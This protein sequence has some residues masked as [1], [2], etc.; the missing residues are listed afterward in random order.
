MI[1]RS[2]ISLFFLLLGAVFCSASIPLHAQNRPS[3]TKSDSTNLVVRRLKF[4]GNDHVRRGTLETLIRTHTNREFLGIPGFTPWYFMWKLTKSFGEKP[5]LLNYKTAAADIQRIT[6][7]YNSIGFLS[8]SADTSYDIFG[9]HKVKVTFHINEGKRSYIRSVSYS[10]IPDSAFKNKQQKINFYKSSPLTG[11]QINDSTFK[12]HLPY[13]TDKLNKERGRIVDYL[14][15]NGYAAVTRDS[16]T[17]FIERSKQ[18]KYHLHVLYKVNPG[19]K[20]KFGDLHIMLAGPGNDTTFTSQNSKSDTLTSKAYVSDDK[21]IYLHVQNSAHTRY[22]LLTNQIHFKPG[23]TFSQKRYIKSVNEFQNLNMMSVL[24]FGLSKN[25]NSPNYSGNAIPV[26]FRLQTKPRNSVSFDVF[27]MKRYGY[28]SGAGLTYN[29]NNLLGKG[30]NLK[31]NVNGSFE[32]VGRKTLLPPAYQNAGSIT[33][34]SRFFQSFQAQADFSLPRLVWPFGW[35]NNYLFFSNSRTRYTLSYDHSDRLLFDINSDIKFNLQDR[36]QHNNRFTSILDLLQLELLDT[37]P[38]DPFRK[39]LNQ[40]FQNDP[41]AL[42]QIL[43]DF[44]PQFSSLFQYTFRSENTNIIK[45]NY[46]YFSEYSIGVGGTIPYL[47]D[48]FVV[49]PG[50]VEGNIPSPVKFSQND[51]TY[52]RYFKVTADY[53]RYFSLSPNTVFAVRGFGG[54]ARA[55]G[56]RKTI[57]LN[58]RFYAGGSNDIRGW[59]LFTLGPGSIP[60]KNVKING[61]EIKLLSQIELRQTV[62]KH[63]LS[64]NWILAF[65]TDAGNVWYGP[66][67]QVSNNNLN[68]STP[69]NNGNTSNQPVNLEQGRFRLNHFYKQIAV[70]SGVGIRIDL[71][72]LILRFDFAFRIHDLQ[73]GWLSPRS[74]KLHFDFGIGQSF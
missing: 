57:P 34:N 12:A 65:F 29:N 61:G 2:G 37:H 64:S 62:L 56:K 69:S 24:Q 28:G 54:F 66:E 49:T 25:G 42:Q 43:E 63:F 33:T 4:K 74:K 71:N 59:S 46:G 26:Y 39:A 10:G 58:Q 13:L 16:I 70:G 41:L 44:R 1:F 21:K 5:A 36:V 52:S 11:Q 40:E 50:T 38:T 53:R 18:N 7:Y 45:R 15:N 31:L 55:Y 35:L 22:S 23:N 27:G 30:E 14:Q 32:Y 73:K 68:P 19:K 72:Y 3:K 17:A 48:R 51:L 6:Q 9:K 8:A 67:E 20:Y 47:I 60:Y